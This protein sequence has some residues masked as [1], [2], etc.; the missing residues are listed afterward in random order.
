MPSWSL[1]TLRAADSH[2]S[3]LLPGWGSFT[4]S[5]G[6]HQSEG[7]FASL[8]HAR[9][10]SEL[11]TASLTTLTGLS[12]WPSR[13]PLM[14]TGGVGVDVMLGSGS[15]F[16]KKPGDLMRVIRPLGSTN[17]RSVPDVTVLVSSHVHEV[18][19]RFCLGNAQNGDSLRG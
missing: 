4:L 17:C 6:S 12:I 10:E 15:V 5:P 19:P 7:C 3:Q 9:D 1:I 13:A 11:K 8:P 18:L 16:L 2:D 14:L